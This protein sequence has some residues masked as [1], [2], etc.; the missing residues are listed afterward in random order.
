MTAKTLDFISRPRMPRPWSAGSNAED[1]RNTAADALEADGLPAELSNVPLELVTFA[2][3]GPNEPKTPKQYKKTAKNGLR[4]KSVTPKTRLKRT[5]PTKEPEKQ[6]ARWH[7]LGWY[8]EDPAYNDK[9]W[10]AAL[11]L[12][13]ATDIAAMEA[14]VGRTAWPAINALVFGNADKATIGALYGENRNAAKAA[15]KYCVR[16]G[17]EAIAREIGGRAGC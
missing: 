10:C 12:E 11:R 5:K 2:A 15:A 1:A 7:R 8:S 9:L 17:L 6:L 14:V 3:P 13:A 4:V 16:A